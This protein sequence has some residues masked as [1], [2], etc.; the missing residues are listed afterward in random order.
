VKLIEE[1]IRLYRYL[2]DRLKFLRPSVST[3][4]GTAASSGEFA[5]L[6]FLGD[7][8]ARLSAGE[9][10]CE[11]WRTSVEAWA[12]ALGKTAAPVI[13]GLGGV[14]GQ[15]DLESQISAI[16]YG[17]AVLE[18]RLLAARED[19]ARYNRLYSALGVLAG[20]GIAIILA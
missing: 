7:C 13:A 1:S 19:A 12:P 8:D 17:A 16:D 14:L 6:G 9:G 4:I 5:S 11:S 15:S 10:F 18:D 3:L 2:R 20:L